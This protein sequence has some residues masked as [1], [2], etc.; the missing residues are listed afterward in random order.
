M[1]TSR[2]ML[3]AAIIVV[4]SVFIGSFNTIIN[5]VTD[6]K[7][8]QSLGYEKVFLTK[9]L[10]QLK[11]GI[12]VFVIGTVLVYFYLMTIKKDYYKKVSTVYSGVSEKK[13]NQIALGG[14]LLVSFVAS[15]SVASN[16][17][18]DILRFF[19]STDFNLQEPIF[20]RDISFYIFKYPLINQVYMMMTTLLLMLAIL[21]VV[22]YFIMMSIRRPTLFETR[23]S[24]IPF[25]PRNIDA[26]NLKKVFSIAA[27]Q[28]LVIGV[29]FFVVQ[30]LGYFLRAYE[31]LYSSRGV[32]YGASYTDI[33]VT[34]L[35]YRV[36]M[37]VSFA[38]AAMLFIGF[39]RKSLK[40]ALTG[41]ILII[42]ISI[43]G[44]IASAGVQSYIVSP[45]EISKE[46]EYIEY[47]INYTQAAY[48]LGNIEEKT[49]AAETNLSIDDI[50]AN[51]ETISNIRINDTRPAELVYNQK[52]GIR[53]YYE[54][55]DV[56]VDRYNING[57]Y[58]QL[59]VS[60]REMNQN[61]FDNL[62][63]IN[64]HFKY[65]HG[66][67]VAVSP[68]NIVT[69]E[70]LP[71]LMVKNIPPETD[72][73]I[74]RV[75][76]PEIYFG[77]L[78]DDYIIVNTLEKEFDYP[79]GNENAQALYEGKAGVE[80]GGLN[81]LL[82][83][84]KQKS[85]KMLLTNNITAESRIV[86]YRNITERIQKIAPYI[87]YDTDPYMVVA[88]GKLYW[89][90]DGYTVSTNYPYSEPYSDNKINYIRNSVKVVVDAYDGA[91]TF[92]VADKE[93]PVVETLGKIFPT[94]FTDIGEMPESLK[95]HIR[96]PQV[97]FNI[98]ADVFRMYHMNDPRVFY[99]KED[100]WDIASEK[101][102]TAEQQIEGTYLVMKLP[103]EEKEEF[104]LSLP[105]TPKTKQNMTALF[106]ARNDGDVYGKLVIY[107]L[108]KN[109]NIYGPIQIENRIDQDDEISQ[110]FT[111]W[112]QVGSNVIRG[113][114]LTIPVNQSLLYVEPIYLQANTENSIPEVKR[115]IVA[116]GD[117]VVMEQTLEESLNKIFGTSSDGS[118]QEGVEEGD[119]T[120]DLIIHATEIFKK[121]QEAQQNGNWSL[122]GVYLNQ[123][124]NV[125]EKLNE[126]NGIV[127]DQEPVLGEA[128]LPAQ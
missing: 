11:V 119:T 1:G 104:V 56:D 107:K 91:V 94:L 114:L 111:L 77:E 44:N 109:K 95:S 33:H 25:N 101:Y 8:F 73:D 15:A 51:D 27:R 75:D 57:K 22:F 84:Y 120:S 126:I 59:F 115:V 78:T 118:D 43:V 93:D 13:V 54:F 69:S 125:L 3:W 116:Y 48:N 49:F 60:G 10:T 86:I 92:Y 105:Y 26:G 96:Y 19:N 128:E 16:L 34:L 112:G 117:Q 97:L 18:F 24:E 61:K 38:A 12:P 98:Q 88:D 53:R 123:L 103:G 58:M 87:Q 39:R 35:M 7:W 122:Y 67:G 124:E 6:Y 72:I 68:V 127:P 9:I 83:A 4:L 23:D 121:A 79:D 65:T 63:F 74:L 37:A 108:P 36:L 31:L 113:N 62:T 21:T 90:V 40:L 110:Q 29:I 50:L 99:N 46:T 85:L 89:I 80:L 102:E 66:Y 2:K 45:D 52:Q 76:R 41:P 81:K 47:N 20:G 106:V 100:E 30:G 32:V 82:F 71:E 64:K 5:F 70:G 28:L 17:W 42:L 55:N 14:S